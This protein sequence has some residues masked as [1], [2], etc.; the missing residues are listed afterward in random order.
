[1]TESV[2][3][4]LPK[5]F[6]TNCS[7]D[8]FS[9]TDIELIALH[10]CPASYSFIEDYM[11]VQDADLEYISE[12]SAIWLKTIDT[13]GLSVGQVVIVPAIKESGAVGAV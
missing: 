6:R 7:Y 1:M 2:K 4:I 8:G 3:Q 12:P 11:D 9:T 13:T 5:K 10:G